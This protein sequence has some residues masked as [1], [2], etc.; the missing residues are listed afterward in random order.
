MSL[1][2][3]KQAFILHIP[4]ILFWF[5][6]ADTPNLSIWQN[7]HI[8]YQSDIH[9]FSLNC[10]DGSDHT[11]LECMER[12]ISW[13]IGHIR[14]SLFLFLFVKDFSFERS[15]CTNPS[16]FSFLFWFVCPYLPLQ[17][18]IHVCVL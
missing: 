1:R 11:L 2:A 6:L 4:T 3:S 7:H 5:Q 18:R 12:W 17:A 15:N 16:S 8:Y 10:L 9:L 13:I 14:A